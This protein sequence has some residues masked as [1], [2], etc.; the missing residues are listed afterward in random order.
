MTLSEAYRGRF[1]DVTKQT[2]DLWNA[3]LQDLEFPEVEA[4]IVDWISREKFP[5]TIADIRTARANLVLEASGSLE[6]SEAWGEVMESVRKCGIYNQAEG[7]A[8]LSPDTQEI[9]RR[10]GGYREFCLVSEDQV[11]TL[12]AQFRD[13]YNGLKARRAR[14]LQTPPKIRKKLISF[15][16]RYVQESEKINLIS[17]EKKHEEF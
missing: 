1:R 4:Y 2:I 13:A 9:V 16:S 5:P 6:A 10:L 3:M 15:A 14:A 12:Y 7:I 17:G 11:R 8:A